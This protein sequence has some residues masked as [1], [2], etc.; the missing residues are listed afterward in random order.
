MTKTQIFNDIV[1]IV[2]H[3]AAFCKDEC[4]ANADI[5]RAQICDSMDDDSFLYTVQ[6]YLASFHLTGHL[7]FQN[8][9]RGVLPFRV[10]RYQNELYVCKT[11]LNSPLNIGDKIIQIDGLSV[12]EYGEQHVDMLCGESE[13]RQGTC[14]FRLLTFAK[15]LTVVRNGETEVIPV[16]LNGEWADE[17]RYSCKHLSDRIT[18]MR[19][20]D[21]ADDVA[22]VQMYQENDTLLRSS[23]YLIID[24]RGNNG[25][26]DSAYFPLLEFCL[27]AGKTAASLEKGPF[28]SGMEINY[29]ERICDS[30]LKLFEQMLNQD[31][32]A[33]TRRMLTQFTNELRQN[34]GKG[35]VPFSSDEDSSID[36]PYV[37]TTLPKRVFVLTDEECASSGDAFVHDI[38]KCD[39]VTVVGRPTMGI[40]D[41]SNCAGEYYGN[42]ALVYPTSRSLYLDEG[43]QMSHRG[44]PVDIYI[45]WTPEHC[46]R[47]VDMDTVLNLIDSGQ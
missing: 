24:V 12:K 23:E 26:N 27:S 40:L 25:G 14:W 33:D 11:A 31:I 10:K 17:D 22:I 46:A 7:S 6:S 41:Y 2:K 28:D 4:G 44:V 45:P 38:S 20:K 16:E 19:L 30:R 1:S 34:R 15:R 8:T 36:L 3:D 35:F 43:I 32:P 47:D 37:G 39:K 9:A 18:Y 29:T 21:F 42:F 5:Y 13:S